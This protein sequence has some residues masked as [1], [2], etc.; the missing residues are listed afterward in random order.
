MK[1]RHQENLQRVG[2]AT[3]GV[4]AAAGIVVAAAIVPGALLA[5]KPFMRRSRSFERY[6]VDRALRRLMR[7]G[8]VEEVR[9]GRVVG[10]SLTDKGREYLARHEL[11]NAQFKQP[12]KWDG[13]WRIITFDISEKRR[14]VRDNLRTHLTRLGLYPIQKSVWLYPYPCADLVRLLKVDLELGRNVQCI[15]FKG[16]EDREDEK[17]WR[18]RF[19]V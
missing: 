15:T 9:R 11:A 5:L 8:L 3:L 4:I 7:R 1:M 2:F 12:K 18:L 6:D 16:F 19:D 13:R 17:L 10:F 14:Y